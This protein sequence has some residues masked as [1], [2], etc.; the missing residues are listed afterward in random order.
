MSETGGLDVMIFLELLVAV[1]VVA[2]VVRY[3]R[4]PYTVALVLAGLGLALLPNTPR[5]EL[6]PE[7][8]LTVFLP[9]LL[10]YGAY[11]LSFTDLRANIMPVT[12][13]A[14]PGVVVTA[15]LAG[16]A[17][18]WSAGIDWSIA[19]LFGAIVAATDPVAVLA[20]FSEVGAPRRL[21]TIV[22]AESLFNDGTALVFF[23]TMVG[24]ATG[25]AGQGVNIGVTFEQFVLGV[26]GSLAL[27]V[28]VGIVGTTILSRIDDALLET[29]ILL[30]IAYGGFLLA[31][32]LGASGPLET[33]TAGLLLGVRSRRVMSPTTRLQAGA[34]WEF[35]DFVAN[36]LLF[37]LVGLEL[38]FL[39]EPDFSHL[40]SSM[41]A[42][43][44]PLVAVFIAITVARALVVWVV[45][46]ILAWRGNPFPAGWRIVLTWAGLRGAVALAAALSLPVGLPDRSLLLTLTFL[47]VLVTLLGQGLTIRPLVQRLGITRKEEQGQLVVEAAVG[48]LRGL[49]AAVHELA[50][51]R[52]AAVIDEHLA[53]RLAARL[54]E[55][56]EQARVELEDA[57]ASEPTARMDRERDAIRHLLHVRR[58]AVNEAA[59]S[60]QI[61][62]GVLRE[63]LSEIDHELDQQAHRW[64]DT[65]TSGN[66]GASIKENNGAQGPEE[67]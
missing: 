8:I 16:M 36:S 52:G 10:F 63:L 3:V 65:A 46:R 61:S 9:V 12:L 19:F 6:T 66:D 17:L 43:L 40:G 62:D 28:A 33:V 37:L 5:V 14:I 20:I 23:T 54:A 2:A 55:R 58:E 32:R 49:D 27:G 31:T 22:T 45:A 39:G 53:A 44:W 34:T 1:A 67:P 4:I 60:G 42:L 57:Y 38:R 47:V 29:A 11:H 7:I 56:R 18:H 21:S 64:Q 30:I 50:A 59:A 25:V 13:L 41:L 24:V 35:L 15:A 26:A 48:R 51:L